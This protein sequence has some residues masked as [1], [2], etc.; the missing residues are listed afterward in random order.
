MSDEGLRWWRHAPWWE[1]GRMAALPLTSKE[2]KALGFTGTTFRL[3]IMDC[4]CR[5]SV[6]DRTTEFRRLFCRHHGWQGV[7]RLLHATTDVN[8][9]RR[10]VPPQLRAKPKPAAKPSILLLCG[11]REWLTDEHEEPVQWKC[12]HHG[13]QPVISHDNSI[14]KPPSSRSRTQRA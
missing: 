13:W 6:G 8:T 1:V 4:S 9:L 10:M 5:L 11:C 2:R 12:R 14:P 7:K 3:A